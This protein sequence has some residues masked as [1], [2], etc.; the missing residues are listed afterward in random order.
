MTELTKN[1]LVFTRGENGILIAQEV[2]LETL[3]DKPTVKI[4]P[5]TRGKLQ[6]VFAM[7][8]SNDIIEKAKA[9]AIIIKYGLISPSLTDD[10][11]EFM[12]PYMSAAIVQAIL[13]VSMNIS[14]ADLGKKT[15]EL[16]Q[17]QEY[18]LKKK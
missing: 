1:D 13:S 17:D 7:A 15:E 18:I 14:Q 16:I 2:V 3:P 11:I 9:D 10:D 8:S 6:E 12:K 5:L 4:V